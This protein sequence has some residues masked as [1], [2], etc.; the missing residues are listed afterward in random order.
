[1]KLRSS[2]SVAR[3][4]SSQRVRG[5]ATP[6]RA[7]AATNAIAARWSTRKG[8]L[9]TQS[10]RRAPATIRAKP[11]TT[12]S[13]NTTCATRTASASHA[14]GILSFRTGKGQTVTTL[15]PS[16]ARALA[17][18][19]DYWGSFL[20]MRDEFAHPA[21]LGLPDRA[22]L[23]S[24]YQPAVR[25]DFADQRVPLSHADPLCQ[26]HRQPHRQAVTPFRHQKSHPL[27]ALACFQ[28]QAPM[29]IHVDTSQSR[30][31]RGLTQNGR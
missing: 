21:D 24:Q 13:T 9:R 6:S 14:A 26:L 31:R 11:P 25:R 10:Q 5:Q 30:A 27:A 28:N 15:S 20:L 29:Y 22:A 12:N 2:R 4:M 19:F 8:R 23:W 7:S 16:V 3:R 1:M 18:A 17:H